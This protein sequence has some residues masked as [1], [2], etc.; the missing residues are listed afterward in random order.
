MSRDDFLKPVIDV[1][2]KRAAFICSNPDCRKL[3][4]APSA[5]DP[6]KFLYIGKAAHI[7]AAASNGPRFDASMTELERKSISNGIFLC[8]NC[9][10][11]IDKNQGID[12]SV[13]RLRAWK[14]GHEE[15]VAGNL[16]K[17]PAGVG[18]EGG[19]GTING[20]RGVI[21]GGRGGDGGVAGTGGK[22]GGGVVNGDDGLII[23]GDGGSCPTADGRGGRGARGPTE[24]VGFETYLWGFGRGGSGANNPEYDARIEALR[25]FRMEYMTRFPGDAPYINAGIEQ[26][27][28]DWINQRLEETG[29]DWR[30]TIGKDGYILPAL[31]EVG[32]QLTP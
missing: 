27:P 28:V 32:Q 30:V 6:E 20:N 3:T 7:C 29:K 11:M 9:A 2:G 8:G 17:S 31:T 15:W 21:I 22:G 12:F 4:I 23:G 25:T 1:L 18:G 24:R 14:D 26:V 13:E 10:D 16:N 19:S 5:D